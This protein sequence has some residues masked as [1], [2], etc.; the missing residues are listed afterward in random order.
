MELLRGIRGIVAGLVGP[1]TCIVRL[2]NGQ[3]AFDVE[4]LSKIV[5]HRK[6]DAMPPRIK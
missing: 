2:S 1:L 5:Q 6:R 3:D 4:G